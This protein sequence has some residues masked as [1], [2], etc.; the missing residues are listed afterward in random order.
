MGI[1]KVE[2]INTQGTKFIRY[3]LIN[4]KADYQNNI[5]HGPVTCSFDIGIPST[6]SG[7]SDKRT[8]FIIPR[9][10]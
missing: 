6:T 9:I 5:G 7:V 1:V 4:R 8:E 2:I 10:A 3:G